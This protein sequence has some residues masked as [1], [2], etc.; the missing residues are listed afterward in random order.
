MDIVGIGGTCKNECVAD[1]FRKINY[2]LRKKRVA[3]PRTSAVLGIRVEVKTGH[4]VAFLRK[5]DLEKQ[6]S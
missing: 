2:K 6:P 3:W 5:E 4:A 1:A